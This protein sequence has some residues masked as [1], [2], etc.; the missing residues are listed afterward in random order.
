MTKMIKEMKISNELEK[1]VLA[2]EEIEIEEC[3]KEGFHDKV[4]R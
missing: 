1:K 2:D 4:N 3:P